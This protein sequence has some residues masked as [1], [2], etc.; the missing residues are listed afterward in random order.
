VSTFPSRPANLRILVTR[1]LSWIYPRQRCSWSSRPISPTMQGMICF[2]IFLLLCFRARLNKRGGAMARC[3]HTLTCVTTSSA[4][5]FIHAQIISEF[6]KDRWR[7]AFF[8]FFLVSLFLAPTWYMCTP[9]YG[10]RA[11]SR[12][13]EGEAQSSNL[14]PDH[15]GLAG[16]TKLILMPAWYIPLYY[17]PLGWKY[18]ISNTCRLFATSKLSACRRSTQAIDL[19]GNATRKSSPSDKTASLLP[20]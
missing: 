14:H 8:F 10:V 17:A 4:Y 1:R 7:L 16:G 19:R 3:W 15:S 12:C 9:T 20:I 13:V 6:Y 11:T 5:T 2:L 18:G